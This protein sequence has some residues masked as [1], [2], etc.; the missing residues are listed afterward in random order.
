MIDN[1]SETLRYLKSAIEDGKSG[2]VDNSGS[3]I[4]KTINA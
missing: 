1:I 4:L 2:Y 3:H